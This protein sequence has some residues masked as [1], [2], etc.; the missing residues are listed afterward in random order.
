MSNPDK[1]LIVQFNDTFKVFGTWAGGYGSGESWKLNSGIVKVEEDSDYYYF[2]GYS[3]SCY[4]CKKTSYGTTGYGY[5]VLSSMD[6]KISDNL[7]VVNAMQ[8]LDD[9]P[10]WVKFFEEKLS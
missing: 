3:G 7:G 1:W 2:Y 9:E 8:V 4:Q 5:S 10:D 6:K